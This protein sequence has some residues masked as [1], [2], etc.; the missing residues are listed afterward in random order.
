MAQITQALQ[1]D[2][3]K[4][5]EAH[6]LAGRLSFLIQAVFGGVGKAPILRRCTLGRRTPRPT[7]KTACPAGFEQHRGPSRRS[8]RRFG[9]ASFFLDGEQRHQAGHVPTTASAAGPNRANNG[10]GFV[11][12]LG[13]AVFYD[14]GVVPPWFFRSKFESR[15]AFIY[16][17]EIFAQ[18]VVLAAFSTHLPG[19][20]TA[21][22][23]NTGARRR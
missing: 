6:K 17:L 15:Q 14:H 5:D 11:L 1:T 18:V 16:M 2:A 3:M 9:P 12:R 7:S 4:P 8:C 13:G 19:A 21:F 20:V 22:I 23:D 10:W